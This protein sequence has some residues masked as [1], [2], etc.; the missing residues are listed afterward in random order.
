MR[1]AFSLLTDALREIT[2]PICKES[3]T[4]TLLSG[5]GDPA[6]VEGLGRFSVRYGSAAAVKTSILSFWRYARH[7]HLIECFMTRFFYPVFIYCKHIRIMRKPDLF[8]FDQG[9]IGQLGTMECNAYS[10]CSFVKQISSRRCQSRSCN[11]PGESQLMPE[12]PM[13]G[14]APDYTIVILGVQM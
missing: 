3:Y 8:C 13:T 5:N 4:L 7:L 2:C 1:L 11:M 14:Y 10:D 12:T 9:L 6:G